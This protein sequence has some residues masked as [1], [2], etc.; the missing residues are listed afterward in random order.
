MIR[1]NFYLSEEKYKFL[2]DI[3]EIS[4]SE[5]IRRAIDKYIEVIRKLKVSQSS[6]YVRINNE[7]GNEKKY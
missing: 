2:E 4:V 7:P 3:D 6:S 1:K 5:H